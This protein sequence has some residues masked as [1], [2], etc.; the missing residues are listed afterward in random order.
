MKD[1]LL[2]PTSTQTWTSASSTSDL[3]F[4]L[5]CPHSQ[6]LWIPTSAQLELCWHTYISNVDPLVRILHKPSISTLIL[7]AE[8]DGF[9]SLTPTFQ[10]LIFSICFGA[11]VS[12]NPQ[13]CWML[14]EEELETLM[15][16][17]KRSVQEALT[18][19]KLLESHEFVLLQ[20]FTLFIVCHP[21]NVPLGPDVGEH[22]G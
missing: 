4:G 13:R 8:N 15:G 19:A 6:A 12:L 2:R 16:R 1:K 20:A 9:G 21:S 18:R 5:P 7:E 22:I 14:F 17:V 3:V 11:I 10:A